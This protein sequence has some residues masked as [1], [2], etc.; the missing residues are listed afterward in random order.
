MY[1]EDGRTET[2]WRFS[3]IGI[4]RVALS[5]GARPGCP[6]GKQR[7]QAAALHMRRDRW[8]ILGAFGEQFRE[9]GGVQV[10]QALETH[11]AAANIGFREGFLVALGAADI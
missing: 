10:A 5:P 1:G 11:A 8:L 2:I 6:G 4:V 9:R 3:A 7:R